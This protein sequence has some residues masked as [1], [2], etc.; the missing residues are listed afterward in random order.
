LRS[1]IGSVGGRALSGH[2][3]GVAALAISPDGHWLV[4]AGSDKTA[5]LWDLS[6]RAPWTSPFFLQ[7]HAGSIQS[8]A[9]SPNGRGLVT[10]S[11]DKTARL[12]DLRRLPVAKAFELRGQ[13]AKVTTLGFSPAGDWLATLAEDNSVW[14]WNLSVDDPATTGIELTGARLNA[15]AE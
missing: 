6:L 3:R 10:G 4:T 2:E 11:S 15:T 13:Q 8:V 12:W 5:R 1:A 14:L 9:F 7:G